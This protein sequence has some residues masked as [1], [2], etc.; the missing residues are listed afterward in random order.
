MS[1][2]RLA[3]ALAS[4]LARAL[5]AP[6]A[7]AAPTSLA[8][9]ISQLSLRAAAAATV[10]WEST[11]SAPQ[12]RPEQLSPAYQPPAKGTLLVDTLDMVRLGEGEGEREIDC[13]S[14]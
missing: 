2:S 9:A 4:Q 5:T 10:R 3:T 8:G 14:A 1:S 11:A 7:A 13:C 6:G 12:P